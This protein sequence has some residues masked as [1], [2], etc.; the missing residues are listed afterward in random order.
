MSLT[1][2]DFCAGIGC[3]RLGLE[4]AGFNCVAFSEINKKAEITYRTFYGGE[5]K[6]FGD[7]M[8]IDPITLPDFDLLIAG[9]PCQTFSV[10]GQRKWMT[11]PRGQIIFGIT[12]ILKEKKIKY[13]ILENVKWLVNHEN[14]QTIQSIVQL[15]DEAGYYAKWEVLNTIN[16]GLPQSR[17]RVYF[18]WVRKD[19][20]PFKSKLVFPIKKNRTWL[21]KYL[22]ETSDKYILNQSKLDTLSHYLKNRYNNWNITINDLLKKTWYIIDTRQSDIRFYHDF[23]PTLRTGRHG[24]IYVRDGKLRDIS[25]LES[26][27]LQ[28]ISY[29]Q[30]IKTKGVIADQDILSQAWNAMSVDVIEALWCSFSTFIAHNSSYD[31]S[32]T[33]LIPNSQAMIPEWVWCHWYIQWLAA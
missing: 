30:A 19:L 26:L 1:F 24:L 31:W 4:R 22:V 18:L 13:F 16:Y 20:W 32:Y 2:M 14:G 33:T 27:L 11:D 5:E 17:E 9:F 3:G 23:S 6:N 10:M 21:A 7:L 25:W 8:K 29:E 28:G 12:K 15:L